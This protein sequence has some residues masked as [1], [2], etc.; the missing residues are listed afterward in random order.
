VY[1]R[2]WTHCKC[3]SPTGDKKY[4]FWLCKLLAL[5]S[6]WNLYNVFFSMQ[7]N[8]ISLPTPMFFLT[9]WKSNF[10]PNFRKQNFGK[11]EKFGKHL[12]KFCNTETTA[13]KIM[14]FGFYFLKKSIKVWQ[15]F[16]EFFKKLVRIYRNN[17]SGA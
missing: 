12:L 13:S 5:F 15:I 14:F 9:P 16:S 8:K 7:N 10:T 3:N 6:P 11:Y 2:S 1:L 17:S 4:K